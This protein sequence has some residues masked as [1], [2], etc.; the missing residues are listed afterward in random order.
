MDIRF[1]APSTKPFGRL[2]NY[3]RTPFTYKGVRW[4]TASHYIYAQMLCTPTTK[5]TLR[6]QKDMNE[7]YPLYLKLLDECDLLTTKQA[8]SDGF[9]VRFQN[10]D[11]QKLLINTYGPIVY[12]STDTQLGIN[13]TLETPGHNLVGIVLDQIRNVYVQ[14][15][16]EER[17]EIKVAELKQSLYRI[18][19][20]YNALIKAL[21]EDSDLL[22]FVED[23]YD[24]IVARYEE[25][26]GELSGVGDLGSV[27]TLYKS[28]QLDPIIL[29]EL[30]S[31][32]NNLVTLVRQR[33]LPK[34]RA[35][36]EHR[37][38]LT[39]LEM[40]LDYH[41]EKKYPDLGPEQYPKAR[42]QNLAKLTKEELDDLIGRVKKLYQLG[43][44]SARLSDKI[45]EELTKDIYKL[46]EDEIFLE[47][48]DVELYEDEEEEVKE[49]PPSPRYEMKYRYGQPVYVYE[50][51]NPPQY[52]P[53][54]PLSYTGML[55]IRNLPYPTI[56]H[57]MIAKKLSVMPIIDGPKRAHN[58]LLLDVTKLSAL[59]LALLAVAWLSAPLLSGSKFM[60]YQ[61]GKV[62]EQGQIKWQEPSQWGYIHYFKYPFEYMGQMQEKDGVQVG[63]TDE[64]YGW[65]LES[66]IYLSANGRKA[67]R[68]GELDPQV[69]ENYL[70][71]QN[72]YSLYEFFRERNKVE[73]LDHHMQIALTQ[74]F[75]DPHL[76]KLLLATEDS[77]LVYDDY[78]DPILGDGLGDGMNLT[79]K[80][81]M[82]LREEIRKSLP[83]VR[84]RE[85]VTVAKS[86]SDNPYL[87]QWV[88]SRVEDMCNTVRLTQNYL[89]R[90]YRVAQ[91]LDADFV[92][93]VLNQVYR[94]C[95]YLFSLHLKV[96]EKVPQ[97]FNG[98][99]QKCLGRVKMKV[100]LAF[101]SR[102]S[103][104]IYWVLTHLLS[105]KTADVTDLMREL[106]RITSDQSKSLKDCQVYTDSNPRNCAISALVNIMLNLH[107]FNQS[108][109]RNP[110]PTDEDIRLA[111]SILLKKEIDEMG[112][113]EGQDINLTASLAELAPD[114]SDEFRETLDWAVNYILE[115]EME[116]NVKVNRLNF[117]AK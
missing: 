101:W 114:L 80:Y 60:A 24:E 48:A 90:K 75:K 88:K 40:Y 91:P 85:L 106:R 113:G 58:L 28:G 15:E 19:L 6:V 63:D 103:L 3:A 61:E 8:L 81:L 104:M 1:Y 16:K 13:P 22:E 93:R 26:Y 33:E 115:D 47:G 35:N 78:V 87:Q 5:D 108:Y 71:F 65:D 105:L 14:L 116:P 76:Q 99:I 44:L 29:E 67:L 32:Q 102:I 49:T 2:S 31:E 46:P 70:N 27:Y 11:L 84:R 98:W 112:K 62:N 36:L 69:P 72:A 45:D 9:N 25:E 55:T 73:M 79:G 38:N 12:I 42:A 77:N 89:L 59:E 18:Y 109:K 97:E 23:D 30:R 74:K 21:A 110:D 52:E 92:D 64:V 50:S 53:L 51:N 10:E 34:L 107:N 4:P 111:L 20:A 117:F 17:E 82:Y 83:R 94:P 43:M 57:Y 86:V 68:I 100:V 41:L 96:K 66:E 56:F 37:K 39:L 7:I 95:S 54:S